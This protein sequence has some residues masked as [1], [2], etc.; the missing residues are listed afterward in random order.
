MCEFREP[1]LHDKHAEI[2]IGPIFKS[3]HDRMELQSEIGHMVL[4]SHD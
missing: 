3:M 4:I 2:S 1:T